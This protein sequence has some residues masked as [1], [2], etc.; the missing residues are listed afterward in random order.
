MLPRRISS[1]LRSGSA[2][3]FSQPL[4]SVRAISCSSPTHADGLF[5]S[6]TKQQVASFVTPASYHL[7]ELSKLTPAQAA[8]LPSPTDSSRQGVPQIGSGSSDSP[9]ILP[10]SSSSSS[11]AFIK[12]AMDA[13]STSV[14]NLHTR[15]HLA[16]LG[17]N[18]SQLEAD[19]GLTTPSFPSTDTIRSI[20]VLRVAVKVTRN[21]I[22][23]NL[24]WLEHPKLAGVSIPRGNISAGSLGFKNAAQGGFEAGHQVSIATFKRIDEENARVLEESRQLSADAWRA[25][26]EARRNELGAVYN[27]LSSRQQSI[28]ERHQAVADLEIELRRA[29]EA[30]ERE[31][32]AEKLD[33][34][35]KQRQAKGAK[36]SSSSDVF[37]QS[38]KEGTSSSIPT[39]TSSST[40]TGTMASSQEVAILESRLKAARTEVENMSAVLNKNLQSYDSLARTLQQNEATLA[41]GDIPTGQY[42]RK[43]IL[44]PGTFS[45]PMGINFQVFCKGFGQGREAFFKA[46]SSPEGESVRLLLTGVADTS[47]VP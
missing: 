30:E 38:L 7:S 40:P 24:S 5:P 36:S 31:Y 28:S 33:R 34:L 35:L 1:A 46:L 15:F 9:A 4:P 44:T 13:T 18:L 23:S 42:T 20:P 2:S 16:D 27:D 12:T 22:I 25:C 29:R 39:P 26:L 47:P 10:P 21:N 6:Y 32:E 3:F 19:L 8:Q 43:S 17:S 11:S 14:R 37:K 45:K 41:K